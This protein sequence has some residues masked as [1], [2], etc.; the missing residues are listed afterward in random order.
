[1][2]GILEVLEQ[3]ITVEDS[4]VDDIVCR[5]GAEWSTRDVVDP[6]RSWAR[7]V[8]REIEEAQIQIAF[9]VQSTSHPGI[10]GVAR[11]N[12]HWLRPENINRPGPRI[13]FADLPH[14]AA[15]RIG[16]GIIMAPMIADEKNAD[17]GK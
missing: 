7:H 10:G 16:Y 2:T 13:G 12:A 1:M 5:C 17:G 8:A 11:V 15:D 6:P 14:D 3:H 9:S 4:S